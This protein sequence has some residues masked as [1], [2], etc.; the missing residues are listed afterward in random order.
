M[1]NDYD[2]NTEDPDQYKAPSEG[3]PAEDDKKKYHDR[4]APIAFIGIWVF[5]CM[6]YLSFRTEF[7]GWP[8]RLQQIME[9]Y[10]VIIGTIAVLGVLFYVTMTAIISRKLSDSRK[11]YANK[12]GPVFHTKD[13][14]R[15]GKYIVIGI[16]F[17]ELILYMAK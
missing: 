12:M 5:L 6:I 2:Y 8:G 10:N 16:V 14:A 1:S 11:L 17:L 3:D 13:C 15:P 7:L 4:M 9:T